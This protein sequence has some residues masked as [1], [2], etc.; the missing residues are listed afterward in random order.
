MPDATFLK[1]SGAK[2][3]K[4][5]FTD[6]RGNTG[7]NAKD[8]L[9]AKGK[10][11]QSLLTAGLTIMVTAFLLFRYFFAIRSSSPTFIDA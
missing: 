3:E 4:L 5:L 8:A 1:I 11:N 2:L 6:N 10:T 9:G 7:V